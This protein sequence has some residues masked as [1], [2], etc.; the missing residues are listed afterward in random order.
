MRESFRA[1]KYYGLLAALSLASFYS[2]ANSPSPPPLCP[3][4]RLNKLSSIELEQLLIASV[5]KDNWTAQ[6]AGQALAKH[7]A[8]ALPILMKLLNSDSTRKVA[9]NVISGLGKDAAPAVPTLI[10][11]MQDPTLRG[12]AIGAL[13]GIGDAAVS[14]V[15]GLMQ[16]ASSKDERT[17]WLGIWGLHY[18][19]KGATLAIPLLAEIALSDNTFPSGLSVQNNAA[20]A[21]G[22]LGQ[23]EPLTAGPYLVK[24]LERPGLEHGVSEGILFMGPAVKPRSSEL[25]AGLLTVLGNLK[26][27]ELG[28]VITSPYC[29]DLICDRNL[30][31]ELEH[32][33]ASVSDN[34]A[35]HAH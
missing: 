22:K 17:A 24:L 20:M 12:D 27:R 3:D 26:N 6:C 5:D 13:A 8:D 19:G 9:I 34:V 21:L 18:I 23:Y 15:P 1:I 29:S 30:R 7:G 11:L 33:L 28:P 32:A 2:E 14:A 25:R 16:F 4:S 35:D 10:S 31:D